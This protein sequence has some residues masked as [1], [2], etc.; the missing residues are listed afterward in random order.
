MWMLLLAFS[1][2]LPCLSILPFLHFIFFGVEAGTVRVRETRI[3][4]GSIRT[5]PKTV[6]AN[7]VSAKAT[8]E[9]ESGPA[10]LAPPLD[11]LYVAVGVSGRP[12]ID[13]EECRW[14]MV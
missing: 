12:V 5:V 3:A 1:T 2:H 10:R 13:K 4:S 6:V 11:A 9:Q 8:S 14:P 7:G